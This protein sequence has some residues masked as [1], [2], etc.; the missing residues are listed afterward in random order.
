MK[1]YIYMLLVFGLTASLSAQPPRRGNVVEIPLPPRPV[2]KG[3]PPH[4]VIVRQKALKHR[5]RV[6]ARR[7]RR[8]HQLPPRP[9][10]VERRVVVPVP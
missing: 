10:V 3:L 8:V 9:V 1:K 2:V 5:H 4:P 6:S 7:H